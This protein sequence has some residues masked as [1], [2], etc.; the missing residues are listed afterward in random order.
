MRVRALLAIAIAAACGCSPPGRAEGDGSGGQGAGGQGGGAGGGGGGG[1]GAG[2]AGGTGGGAPPSCPGICEDDCAKAGSASFLGCRFYPTDLDQYNGE[3]GA[4]NDHDTLH[5]VIAVGNPSTTE[6]AEAVL[7]G[8]T[9]GAW[10]EVAK[11]T[12]AAGSAQAFSRPEDRHVEG[13]GRRAGAAW[14]VRSNRPVAVYQFNPPFEDAGVESS[15]ASLL[16]TRN[17]FGTQ[18]MVLTHKGDYLPGIAPEYDITRS[19]LTVVGVHDGSKVDITVGDDTAKGAGVVALKK[20]ATTTVMLDEGDVFQLEAARGG[21]DLSGSLI[22][23]DRPVSVFAGSEAA[24]VGMTDEAPDHLEEPMPPLDTWGKTFVMTPVQTGGAKDG[25]STAYRVLASRDGTKV[26]FEGPPGLTLPDAFTL[27]RGR[28]K[29]VMLAPR[30]GG[31]GGFV[32]TASEPVLAAQYGLVQSA[33]VQA[34]PVEQ[35]LGEFMFVTLSFFSNNWIVVVR[36]A[37]DPV[38]LD[39]KPLPDSLFRPAGAG[40]EVAEMKTEKCPSMICT[41]RIAGT[42]V[43]VL[44]FADDACAYGYVGGQAFKCVNLT[45]GC[46]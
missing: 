46:R 2:G 18:H 27:D 30:K 39:G 7:E 34:V 41:H 33:M 17:A 8:R 26:S 45:A 35:Y 40:Y 24:K 28:W 31:G 23:S 32:I 15:G 12:I 11:A 37:G 44:A 1:A 22:G 42:K 21:G 3:V 9:A 20:G 4:A 36:K 19:T 16:L 43:S 5:F 38:T 14:R 25:T 6:T 29:E 13:S 10:T